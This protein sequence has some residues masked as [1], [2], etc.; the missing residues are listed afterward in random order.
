MTFAVRNIKTS[1]F[2]V[3]DE[4][5]FFVDAAAVLALQVTREGF[6]SSDSFHTAVAFDILD[7]L[8]DAF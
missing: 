4:T 8:V 6:R 7:K 1:I 3:I 5:V 2:H